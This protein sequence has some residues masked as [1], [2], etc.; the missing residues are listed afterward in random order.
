MKRRVFSL[1]FTILVSFAAFSRP[2]SAAPISL[3]AAVEGTAIGGE[4]I[5]LTVSFDLNESIA[6]NLVGVELYVGFTGLAPVIG[7][8]ALGDV[9]DL[10]PPADLLALDGQCSDFGG[11][12]YPA[13]DSA[14]PQHYLSLVSIFAPS[15]ATGPGTLFTLQFTAPTAGSWSLNLFGDDQTALLWDPPPT[16]DPDDLGCAEIPE[17]IPFAIVLPGADVAS[18][19]ARVDV[20]VTVTSPPP[21]SV[22]EPATLLLM[23]SGLAYA[24]L[25]QRALRRRPS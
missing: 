4:V 6:T 9:F 14:S 10:V 22:P 5:D 19:T 1:A 18:G 7:S 3:A 15:L 23:G 11:C 24:A 20:G 13:D 25:R 2:A 8:Y 16:C 21:T 17:P 12:S